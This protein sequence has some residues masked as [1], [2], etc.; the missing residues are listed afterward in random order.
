MKENEGKKTK[1]EAKKTPQKKPVKAK[2]ASYKL[3]IVESPTKIKTIQKF[4]SSD[5]RVASSKGHLIDLPKSQ[6]GIDIDNQFKPRYIT[7]RGKGKDL[8]ELTTQAKKAEQILLAT[9]PDRE[10]EAI[11]WLLGLSLQKAI[12]SSDSPS[13]VGVVSDAR[14]KRIEFNEI[15]E[16]AVRNA[17]ENPREI[18]MDKVASQQARRILDRLVGYTISP[19]IQESFHSRRFSAG[20]V[21]SACLK[22]LCDREEEIEKFK[23]QEFWD[24]SGKFENKSGKSVVCKLAKING[25][26]TNI[27]DKAAMDKVESDLAKADYLV[28]SVK[29]SERNINPRPPY[30]TSALQRDASTRLGFRAQKTMRIAQSLYEGVNLP[31]GQ[32]GLITYMRTDSTRIS[33]EGLNMARDFLKK[34]FAPEY[35]PPTPNIYAGK[36]GAQ[37]AHEAIRPTSVARTP[38][39]IKNYLDRDQYRLYE[40]IYNRFLSSQMTPGVDNNV[41]LDILGKSENE[42]TFRFSTSAVK[43]DGFRAIF[44]MEGEKKEKAP[45]LVEKDKVQMMEMVKEQK[46]TTPP[47]RYTE[48]SLILKME[49][50]GIGRPATYVPTIGTLDKRGYIHRAGKT[51][52]PAPLGRVVNDLVNRFFPDIVDE[53]FTAMMEE[54]LDLIAENKLDR[55][56]MLSTFYAP[57]DEEVQKAKGSIE[58]LSHHIRV[59]IGRECPK[60]GGELYKKTGKNGIF[61]GCSNFASG[62]RYNESIPVGVCPKCGGN[63]YKRK[64]KK[65]RIFYG[66]ENYSNEEIHCDFLMNLEPSAQSCPRCGSIMGQQVRKSGIT[67]ICQNL[68]CGYVMAENTTD[69]ASENPG[70]P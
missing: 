70:T 48:A 55:V 32:T 18:D 21:Q 67:H 37:D 11:S 58:D 19:I 23:P 64:S 17:L 59:P 36:K 8:K 54:K 20:R 46:F 12:S 40:L 25:V 52:K 45:K 38:E 65:N 7:I 33:E 26:N 6:M 60:C 41:S 4:L 44:P 53:K 22:I 9:D 62:C 30:I 35:L 34:N 2:S 50:S 29:N 49:N 61:I 13:E 1:G 42:Y 3:I 68:E 28:Q 31:E 16:T 5:Y 66:C 24:V 63:L 69:E 43:F 10:G 14:I 51:L 47:P 15:T 57:F 27:R 56:S 39:S